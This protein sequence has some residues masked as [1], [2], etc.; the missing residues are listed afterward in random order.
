[1]LLELHLLIFFAK[2]GNISIEFMQHLF[3]ISFYAAFHFV[4][5]YPTYSTTV[6][7]ETLL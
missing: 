3:T 4:K 6:I 5:E 2:K 7:D 1:M